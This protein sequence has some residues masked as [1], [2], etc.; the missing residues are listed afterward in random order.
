MVSALRREI[1]RMFDDFGG[2]MWRF[3]GMPRLRHRRGG[4]LD[5]HGQFCDVFSHD[6]HPPILLEPR[7]TANPSRIIQIGMRERRV[8]PSNDTSSEKFAFRRSL[9]SHEH[10]A[11]PRHTQLGASFLY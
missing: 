11:N 2:G 5:L 6:T 3:E 7:C 4:L 10:T 1:D 8:N 9:K